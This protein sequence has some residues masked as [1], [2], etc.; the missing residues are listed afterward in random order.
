MNIDIIQKRIELNKQKMAELNAMMLKNQ[1]IHDE[2]LVECENLNHN[3]SEMKSLDKFDEVINSVL[4]L[5]EELE[6]TE[7]LE[8]KQFKDMNFD[9]QM[10]VICADPL[11]RTKY[12]LADLMGVTPAV[13]Y[14][15]CKRKSWSPIS[16]LKI[17][18]ITHG[19]FK[20]IDMFKNIK[21]SN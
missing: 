19:R 16:A 6:I 18:I 13:I 5:K 21:W 2:I 1:Q 9:Q 15:I 14:A 4:R 12:N 17:E 20:A 8:V 10:L 3:L 11:I 7:E